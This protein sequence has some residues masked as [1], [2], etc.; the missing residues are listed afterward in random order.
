MAGDGGVGCGGDG[1]GCRW[2]E[3]GGKGAWEERHGCGEVTA[4]REGCAV[5][6]EVAV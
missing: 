5:Q 6:E 3:S 2:E 1:G 4:Q